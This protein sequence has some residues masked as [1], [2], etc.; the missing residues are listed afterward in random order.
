MSRATLS[1]AVIK[2]MEE[3]RK[4]NEALRNM[5]K[6]YQVMAWRL[7]P[8]LSHDA[9]WLLPVTCKYSTR[10]RIARTLLAGLFELN[11]DLWKEQ[12]YFFHCIVMM[13]RN[14]I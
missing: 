9:I 5:I 12:E 13:L 1:E 10:C 6:V 3:L 8:I 4:G 2:D 14:K 7:E 11:S